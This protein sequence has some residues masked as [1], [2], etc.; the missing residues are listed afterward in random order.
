MRFNLNMLTSELST[1]HIVGML[2]ISGITEGN[3]NCHL[4]HFSTAHW[5]LFVLLVTAFVNIPHW[6]RK[7]TVCL[8]NSVF[9]YIFKVNRKS[10]M[11][12]E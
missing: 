9:F 10:F 3:F 4:V 5:T 1:N 2:F 6:S 12:W 11:H 7:K 8:V